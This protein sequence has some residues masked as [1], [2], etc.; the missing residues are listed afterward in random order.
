MFACSHLRRTRL[1]ECGGCSS[2][3]QEVQG[4]WAFGGARLRKEGFPRLR[5]P[6]P[7][8]LGQNTTQPIYTFCSTLSGQIVPL[9]RFLLDRRP[10]GTPHGRNDIAL[11]RSLGSKPYKE[12]A[13]RGAL[14]R[15]S[16]A[17]L[18]ACMYACLHVFMYIRM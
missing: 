12:E 2:A 10:C 16:P 9:C 17:Y 1:S 14:E 4:P 13:Y 6:G 15:S 11:W 8:G 18:Y 7:R 5:G 3:P